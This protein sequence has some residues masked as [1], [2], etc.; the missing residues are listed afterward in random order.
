MMIEPLPGVRMVRD[1]GEDVVATDLHA[2]VGDVLRMH[3]EDLVDRLLQRDDDG[4]RQSVEVGA[5][6]QS[7][8]TPCFYQSW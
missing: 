8:G 4:A 1:I 2:L 3:E 5:R 7:H 6:D